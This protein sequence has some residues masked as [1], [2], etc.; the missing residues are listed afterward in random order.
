MKR[1]ISLLAAMVLCLSTLAGC[2]NDAATSGGDTGDTGTQSGTNAGTQ[3]SD[4]DVFNDITEP[5]TLNVVL[6]TNPVNGDIPEM[7]FWDEIERLSKIKFEVSAIEA[8]VFHDRKTL[9]II[10]DQLPD[11]FLGY[12]EFDSGEV[13]KY[14]EEGI[15]VDLKDQIPNMKNLQKVLAIEPNTLKGATTPDG[16]IY[17]LPCFNTRA[18]AEGDRIFINTTWLDNLG[19]SM[20]KTM[21]EFRNVL[22]AFRDRDPDG[23]GVQNTIPI[24]GVGYSILPLFRSAYGFVDD[25][26]VI[27]GKVK[28]FPMEDSYIDY[29]DTLNQF[30]TDNLIDHEMISQTDDQFKTKARA[31]RVGVFAYSSAYD[32]VGDEKE[33]WSQYE[34]MDPITAVDGV[35]AKFGL[36]FG[37]YEHCAIITK[38]NQHLKESLAFLDFLYTETGTTMLRVGPEKGKWDGEGGYTLNSEGGAVVEVPSNY[39]SEWLFVNAVT[40]CINILPCYMPSQVM[41]AS[42]GDEKAQNLSA[43]LDKIFQ[44]GRYKMPEF[45]Y[46]S[47]EAAKINEILP[48]VQS[49]V[50][51]KI[52]EYI[53]GVKD[54]QEIVNDQAQ[55]KKMGIEEVI[56]IRQA[57]YDRYQAAE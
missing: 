3:A 26:D 41:M 23:D 22:T 40:P 15:F 20:P 19:L 36:D 39:E 9:M 46:T 27:D 31:M 30:Y 48:Y 44:N 51:A 37:I 2:G 38:A 17:S 4:T 56:Q 6:K 21:E 33:K 29:F 12:A 13:M 7:W 50:Q 42:K 52:P 11:M 49:D 28:Y 57:G 55:W 8:S 5:V 24:S 53:I 16:S 47:E 10:S 54:V 45:M 1:V 34:A 43:Q 25:F 14:G 35:D 32:A 18:Q